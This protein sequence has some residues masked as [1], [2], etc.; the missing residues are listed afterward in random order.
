MTSWLLARGL[1]GDLILITTIDHPS[2]STPT[3]SLSASALV[4][5]ITETIS[6]HP[7]S[8]TTTA[9]SQSALT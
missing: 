7:A 4:R 3:S 9:V 5:V 2:P 8:T 1:A 6:C